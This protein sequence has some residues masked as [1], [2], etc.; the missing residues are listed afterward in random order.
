MDNADDFNATAI[1]IDLTKFK[2]QHAQSLQEFFHCYDVEWRFLE[3]DDAEM[4]RPLVVLRDGPGVAAAMAS[5]AGNRL[6]VCWI[7]DFSHML[8]TDV[9]GVEILY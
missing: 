5:L 9:P 1:R 2:R 7:I 4:D 3:E 6:P 8:E